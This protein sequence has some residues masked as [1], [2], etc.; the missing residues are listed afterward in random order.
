M[1]RWLCNEYV[2]LF[3]RNTYNIVDTEGISV[4]FN[5][6]MFSFL[7]TAITV[8]AGNL[9]ITN[10]QFE[11]NYFA[12]VATTSGTI[13]ITN[14][15]FEGNRISAGDTPAVTYQA[16]LQISNSLFTISNTLFELNQG[17]NFDLWLNNT[18][19]IVY[20]CTF[21]TLVAGLAGVY[22]ESTRPI[23]ISNSIF[24]ETQIFHN[25]SPS[26]IIT[27]GTTTEL[28][29]QSLEVV[30]NQISTHLMVLSGTV[31]IY[32]SVFDNN[33]LNNTGIM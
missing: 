32:D 4:T 28:V 8:N 15:E 6:I 21:T 16:V 20:N 26:L 3:M 2:Y 33:S 19:G 24:K 10:C 17:M 5:D 13:Q 7:Q 11:D 25:S 9:T 12:I 27:A 23:T 14:S 22:V 31:S 1:V 18:E 30:N 29:L